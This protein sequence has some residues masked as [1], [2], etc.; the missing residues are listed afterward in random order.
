MGKIKKIIGGF[1]LVFIG[2]IILGGMANSADYAEKTEGLT[3]DQLLRYQLLEDACENQEAMAWLQSEAAAN[4][5]HKKCQQN[6]QG[7]L[8]RYAKENTP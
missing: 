6:L 4:L 3:E 5:V 1:F 7:L 8:D 2:L